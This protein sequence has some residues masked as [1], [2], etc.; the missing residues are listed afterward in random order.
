LPDRRKNGKGELS[1]KNA[2]K[3]EVARAGNDPATHGFSIPEAK[4]EETQ[5]PLE[6]EQKSELV[7][8]ERMRQRMQFG[9]NQTI[10]DEEHALLIAWRNA[11]EGTKLKVMQ[12]LSRYNSG[13]R[14]ARD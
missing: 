10:S 2:E 6:N 13:C 1:K 4:G 9:E 5:N 7:E 3:N 8:S 14:L 11:D 12:C